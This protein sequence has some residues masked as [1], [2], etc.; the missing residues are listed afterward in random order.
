M[1]IGGDIA[2]RT[3]GIIPITW[4]ALSNDSRY[5]E[6]LLRDAVE[7]A[8]ETVFGELLSEAEED[9]LPR[10]VVDFTAKVAAIEII[11]A[12]IDFWMNEVIEESATGTNEMHTYIDRAE[13]LAEQRKE[14]I[15]E[16]RAKEIEIQGLTGYRRI[17]SRAIPRSNTIDDELLTPDPREFPRPY[18][19][20]ALS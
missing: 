19:P 14:L 12:G 11:P 20:T 4:D 10:I 9:A 16:V 1:A 18:N 5:G 13:K 3:R 17:L 7:L 15:K 8:E 2:T 6:S